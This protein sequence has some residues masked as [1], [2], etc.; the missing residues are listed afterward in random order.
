MCLGYAGLIRV[1]G[2]FKDS[3]L[4]PDPAKAD[5]PQKEKA[6]EAAASKSTR[7]VKVR[8]RERAGTSAALPAPSTMIRPSWLPDNASA[9]LSSE[10]MTLLAAHADAKCDSDSASEA[11]DVQVDLQTSPLK[12]L[13]D[14]LRLRHDPHAKTLLSNNTRILQAIE[15][16]ALIDLLEQ[17]SD[18]A[19]SAPFNLPS[20]PAAAVPDGRQGRGK[21]AVTRAG[22]LQPQGQGSRLFARLYGADP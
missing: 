2:G 9:L 7:T 12:Q 8:E 5:A 20:A 17:R 1:G 6:R 14:R 13:C 3:A 19:S 11:L 4:A 18:P 10:A 22:P 21:A 16:A 15:A